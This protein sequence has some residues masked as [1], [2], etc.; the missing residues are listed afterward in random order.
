MKK[1]LVFLLVLG[2]AAPAMASDWHFYGS[3]RT[4]LGYYSVDEDYGTSFPAGPDTDATI[5]ANGDDDSGTLLNIFGQSRFGAK[6][7]VSDNLSGGFELGFSE[8]N[9]DTRDEE[10][11]YLRLLYGEWNFGAG[12]LRIGK[13]YTPAT[14][15]GYSNMQGDL[16]DNGD[17][18][19]LVSGLA[20]IGR[21]PQIRLSFG[22]F[23]F[24]LIQ[25]NSDA[26]DLGAGD[27][28]FTIP[29]VE[30][31]YVFRTPVIA[32]RPILA[33]QTYEVEDNVSGDSEDVTS[34]IGGLG[35]SLKLGPAYIKM[36]GSYVQNP[37]NYGQTNFLV[38]DAIYTYGAGGATFVNGDVEDSELLQGTFVV[39]AKFNKSVGVEAG[40]GYGS[41]E[42]E[43]AAGVDVEQTGMVFY[44]QAPITLAKGFTLTPEIGY[45]DRDDL[46]VA[47]ADIPAGDMTY[48]DVKFQ[49]NF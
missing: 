7:I 40:V 45:L 2:L 27:V 23:D 31:A 22:N 17:A 34:F 28:D 21:Q 5:R 26:D 49:I 18:V 13:H 19:M 33:F 10:R 46:E 42:Q 3:V 30:A 11:V 14:F 35:L 12:K 36:T 47:G 24:A 16:G 4:H 48:L 44:V 38:A 15:L 29:R 20:Y 25:P 1:L 41:I 9:N 39:G 43:I 6:A 8:T 32:I 37:I